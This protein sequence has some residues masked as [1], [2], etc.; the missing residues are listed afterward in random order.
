M[1]SEERQPRSQSEKCSLRL[2]ITDHH[3]IEIVS[4]ARTGRT[5]D[6]VARRYC[7][8]TPPRIAPQSCQS[9]LPG[10]CA[11]YCV[12]WT[13]DALTPVPDDVMDAGSHASPS[14]DQR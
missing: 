3:L 14:A 10:P 12:A 6:P 13:A 11:R 1:R 9:Y 4:D 8:R 2:A 7:P 5:D